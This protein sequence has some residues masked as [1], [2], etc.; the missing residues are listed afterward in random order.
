MDEKVI[1]MYKELG[2]NM[3]LKIHVLHSHV[4]PSSQNLW[5]VGDKH[6]Q[7][8]PQDNGGM[9]TGRFKPNYACRLLD[10]Y[11]ENIN[12]NCTVISHIFVKQ[13]L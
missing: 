6:G 4:D 8:F 2:H 3:P 5:E 13:I 11:H 10:I 1:E 7:K 9:V 12:F